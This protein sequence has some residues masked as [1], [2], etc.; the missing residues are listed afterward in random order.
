MPDG[1]DAFATVHRDSCIVSLYFQCDRRVQVASYQDGR[2]EDTHVFGPDWELIGYWAEAGQMAVKAVKDTKPEANLGEALATGQ[3][4]GE[5]VLEF[6]TG[7]LKG[8][9]AA[10]S[11][12][13][14]FGGEQIE[15]SGHSLR[16]GT[17]S[18]RITVL[19]NGVASQY[20]FTVYATPD[21]SLFIEGSAEVD[22]F[23]RKTQLA[24]TPRRIAWPDEA[25][26]GV[27]VSEFGCD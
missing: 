20:D 2:L 17:L 24:W 4:T 13:M 15:L 19:K 1:C 23:G 3:S 6:Q 7:V 26:F 21:A 14:K 5:R 18:R 9:Q 22:Q 12:D 10:L 25:G 27:T 11:S 16:V 8:E